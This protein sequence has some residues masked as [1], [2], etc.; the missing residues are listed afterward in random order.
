MKR[1][2]ASFDVPCNGLPHGCHD[3][4]SLLPRKGVVV[5]DAGVVAIP[6]ETTT[7][8]DCPFRGDVA[9]THPSVRWD[10]WDDG[11]PWEKRTRCN[12]GCSMQHCDRG[13]LHPCCV[14][15]RRVVSWPVP[16]ETL[17]FGCNTTHNPLTQRT[18]KGLGWIGAWELSGIVRDQRRPQR[19]VL[20]SEDVRNKVLRA[21][22][23]GAAA[24]NMTAAAPALTLNDTRRD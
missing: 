17:R 3:A 22:Y 5:T 4:N 19:D 13:R 14:R 12:E 21:V 18:L 2:A 20:T 1:L 7:S 8:Q 11:T 15:R 16:C 6:Y 24:Q 10:M 23:N 9:N